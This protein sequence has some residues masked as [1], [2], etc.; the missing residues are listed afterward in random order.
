MVQNPQ[1]K[2]QQRPQDYNW[3]SDPEK[4]R[5][6]VQRQRREINGKLAE[7]AVAGFERPC[8]TGVLNEASQGWVCDFLLDPPR[9]PLRVQIMRVPNPQK[10]ERSEAL[11]QARLGS[12]IFS[13][14]LKLIPLKAGT[15]VA[16]LSGTIWHA[17]IGL[18]LSLHEHRTY[19][20]RPLYVAVLE[21]LAREL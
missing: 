3:T 20:D 11:W 18:R 16:L 6:G 19:A 21:L 4:V 8:Y 1:R 5:E 2:L 15:D 13:R 14:A 17:H 10:D 9:R 7:L 12:P